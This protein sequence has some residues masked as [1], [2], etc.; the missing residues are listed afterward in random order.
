MRNAYKIL[1]RKPEGNRPVGRSRC[2][3]KDNIKT[4][5]RE[6]GRGLH[7]SSSGLGL[8]MGSCEHG[9]KAKGFHKRRKLLP[10]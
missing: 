5:V 8:V 1:V 4:D 6:I 10:S 7:S 9:T 2:I 3:W